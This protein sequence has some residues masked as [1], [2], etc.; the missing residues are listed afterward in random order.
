MYDHHAI[1][2]FIMPQA[3]V[4]PHF[5]SDNTALFEKMIEAVI[6]YCG[7]IV[8]SNDQTFSRQYL[9]T[10]SPQEHYTLIQT[11]YDT[12]WIRD[13][14]PIAL[15]KHSNIHWVVPTVS[16]MKRPF[17][18][19]LFFRI[20]T[21]K[22]SLSPIRGLAHGNLIVASKGIAFSTSEI[23][24]HTHRPQRYRKTLGIRKWII[25][26]KF[27]QESTG[28]ADLYVRVLSPT[29]IAVAWNLSSA[30]DRAKIQKLISQ[31]KRF[32][33]QTKILKIPIR[34]KKEQYASL[35]NWIQ[36][37]THLIIPVYT[38]TH[39]KDKIYTASILDKHGFSTQFIESPTLKEGG[40]LHCLSAS[41]FV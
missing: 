34:S 13:R 7:V 17:D 39:P 35:L 29:L 6:P 12:P 15:K 38:L 10:V 4:I 41:V 21:K 28:H 16:K 20:S 9:S 11:R 2:D 3:V 32:C 30:E 36:L 23:Y 37:G 22:T 40:S 25:F 26:E 19:K 24:D 5:N 14:S 27:T 8:L 33:K 18:D 31:I 1:A